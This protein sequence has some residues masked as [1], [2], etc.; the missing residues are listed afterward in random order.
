M[1]QAS[2][3]RR[4]ARTTSFILGLA[5]AGLSPL[6]LQ[7]AQ[8]ASGNWNASPTNGVWE[9]AGTENNW[10]TGAATFPGTTAS[11]SIT[12]T[13]SATFN[14][15]SSVT[16]ISI[17]ATS[18]NAFSLNLGTI[19]F[20]GSA[21]SNYTIGSTTGNALVMTSNAN[22]GATTT[23]IFVS[24]GGRSG[25]STAVIETINAPIVI[26]PQTST[27]AGFYV[28]QNNSTV[29]SNGDRLVF[30]GGVSGGTTTSTVALTLRGANTNVNNAVN[31]AITNGGAAGGLQLFKNDA[32]T[33]TLA[34]N[35]SYTGT[36][37]VTNGTLRITGNYTGGGAVDL[38][39]GGAV[40]GIQIATSGTVSFGNIGLNGGNSFFTLNSGTA[41][42]GS[43]G[44]NALSASRHVDVNGG[45]LRITADYG[46]N[47]GVLN[48]NGGTVANAKSG[49]ATLTIDSLNNNF[50]GNHVINVQAGGGS[51]DTTAGNITSLALLNGASGGTVNITG[52][53]TFKA[54]ATSTGNTFVVS[55][56]GS[57][58]WDIN[59]AASFVAGLAGGGNITNTGAA[60]SLTSNVASGAQ[61]FSGAIGGGA[62]VSLIKSGAGTQ[63]ISGTANSLTGTTSINAGALVVTGALTT[64]AVTV[65][66]GGSL[67]GTGNGTTTGALGSVTLASGGTLAPGASVADSSVGTLVIGNLDA[68]NGNTR[69][70]LV[71]PGASDKI[72]AGAA[73]FSS[74]NTFTLVGLPASG[75][76]TLV[77]SSTPL[78]GSAPTLVVP[79]GT[80]AT[81]T[82]HYGDIDPNAFQLVVAGTPKSLTWTGAASNVWD[83]T[84]AVNWTDGAISEQFY[85]LDTVTFDDSGANKSIVLNTTVQPNSATFN[86]SSGNDY[87]VSGTGGIAGLATTVTKSGSGKLT[88]ATNNT[89]G[90][91]TTISAGTLQVGNGGTAGSL[92]TGTVLDNAALVFN[93]SDT[94]TL[95]VA[96]NGTG[97]LQQSGAGTLV[98]TSS[99][100]YS[101]TTTIDSGTTVQLGDGGA[102]GNL[103]VTSGVIDNG[104]LAYNRS[105][106]HTLN[107]VISGS[108]SVV[109]NSGTLSLGGN[110]TYTGTT[111]INAGGT[112]QIG[113]GGTSGS[114]GTGAITNN[115]TL[116]FNRSD[117]ISP[118]SFSGSG[119]IQQDGTG[120]LLFSGPSTYT[121]PTI[122]NNGTVAGLHANA[123]GSTP[124]ISI[125]AAGTLSLRG[126]S[127]TT[128]TRVSDSQPYTV[129]I[130]GSGATI[131]VDRATVAGTSAKTM[132]IGPVTATTT[133]AAFTLNFTGANNTGLSV[134]AINGPAATQGFATTTLNF[135]N[136]SGTTT[137]DSYTGNN[138]VGNE[139]V[140]FVC[141]GNVVVTNAINDP[142]SL[143]PLGMNKS[144]PGT[145]TLLGAGNYSNGTVIAAGT[146]A[147]GND[148]AFGFGDVNI[149]APD[150]V[151]VLQSTDST[152]RTI[153]NNIIN[154]STNFTFGGTGNLVF[155]GG[156][157]KGQFFKNLIVNCPVMTINGSVISNPGAN[158]GFSKDGTGTLVFAGANSYLGD[159]LVR[160][161]TLTVAPT[162]SL[163]D[164]TFGLEVSNNNTTGPGTNTVLNLSTV[165][166]TNVGNLSGFIST[167]TSGT[168]TATINTGGSGRN[169]NVTQT[170]AFTAA[171]G[172][173]GAGNFTLTAG[174]TATLTLTGNL[175]YTGTTTVNA[176]TLRLQTNLS[177]TSSLNVAGGQV[178]LASNGT[179]NRV[180]RAGSVSTAAGSKV[181][182]DNNKMVLTAQ[183]VGTWNGTAYT[184][185]TGLIASGYGPNQDFGGTTGIVTTQTTATGGNTLH[186]IGV[187]SNTDLGLSTFGGVSVGANDTLAMFTY[188]GDA[189]LDGAI[190]GD[191]YFQIDS[192][193][194]A[195][196][197]GW[198][199]GDFNYDGSITGDDYFVIDSNFSAQGS[200]IPTSGGVG[201][202][203]A[204]VQAVPEP[205]SIGLIGLAAANLLG[206]RRRRN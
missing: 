171:A 101:G 114:P 144:G 62:N 183:S 107:A 99:N 2:P 181:N 123:F 169:F 39:T 202:G 76:Y 24:G 116:S 109:V 186:N 180:I 13:E 205:A 106:A 9:A 137:I 10:S 129:N 191:D 32:G 55:V 185:V 3:R 184:G 22:Q 204:G 178:V 21:L 19:G 36:T 163:G 134:G 51:F 5:T 83:V 65:N 131:N 176:G 192:G 17:D 164:P 73:T 48:L 167:P 177:G 50:S 91:G 148:N 170:T 8:A 84:G 197:H 190:T 52:G 89:Y 35:N 139:T 108:G 110:N 154:S 44:E 86:N 74:S 159:T 63:V 37:T 66:S 128:F 28:F 14:A 100:N 57:S 12:N 71:S 150:A 104:T 69:F 29:L 20:T 96:V 6:A 42:V 7:S 11:G 53:N 132:T 187:A 165:N 160:Q 90:G 193:F 46:A 200:P 206:R 88:L 203:L 133:A 153:S 92:G 196:A 118:P 121:G 111:T 97:S 158:Q 26:A 85:N 146:V 152:P 60:A 112:L 41:I 140:N 30:N 95:S 40:G 87:T 199:N 102:T 64:S 103:G 189:N 141:N 122:I 115:G 31:G 56:Q 172:I 147:I 54:G 98:I 16:N 195:G 25:A 143:W 23:Q 33:W 61:T 125:S 161:G 157:N 136:T 93:R 105:N 79:T 4:S 81:Y 120:T 194:P 43:I 179:F 145:L 94:N 135:L 18:S 168:N 156:W 188:G 113:S 124:S 119:A 77:Q 82:P 75:T 174:S 49:G 155:N 182:I 67:G 1:K 15:V 68:T 78:A 38:S 142:P 173:A 127:S 201:G 47:S 34:G 130:A 70:D 162:G 27:S 149:N 126:D 175:T 59:G 80:R 72:N 117:T 166:D 151:G 58:S 45:T 138:T 198:F